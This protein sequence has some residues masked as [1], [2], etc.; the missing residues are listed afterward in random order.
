[1]VAG[2]AADSCMRVVSRPFTMISMTEGT[3]D[4]GSSVGRGRNPIMA[5]DTSDPS[6]N[7]FTIF[8]LVDINRDRVPIDLLFNLFF[9]VALHTKEDGRVDPF[10]AVK[11]GLTMTLP[12]KFLLRLHDLFV[13]QSSGKRER[14]DKP[15]KKNKKKEEKKVFSHSSFLFLFRVF[16]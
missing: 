4:S 15:C 6:V 8:F 5:S 10:V 3:F 9:P 13:G 1:M 11:I 7:R 2:L 16:V 14:R 12:A